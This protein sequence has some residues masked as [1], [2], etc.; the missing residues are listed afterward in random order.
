MLYN[1]FI[2]SCR[3]FAEFASAEKV[4]VETGLTFE[5]ARD[6]CRDFNTHRTDAE[7]EAG[8]KMEFISQD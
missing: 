1:T 5:E 7:T 2:R 6:A 4:E 3:N 8:T